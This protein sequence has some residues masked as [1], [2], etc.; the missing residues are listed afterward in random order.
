MAYE[1]PMRGY[2]WLE[3]AKIATMASLERF[4]VTFVANVRLKFRILK[5][6]NV[7]LKTVQSSYFL[8][9]LRKATNVGVE[10]KNTKAQPKGKP[11]PFAVTVTL[12]LPIIWAKKDRHASEVT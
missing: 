10:V 12:N 4:G 1:G 3:G 11:L 8:Q 7:Q 6:E 5:T 9:T 2:Q